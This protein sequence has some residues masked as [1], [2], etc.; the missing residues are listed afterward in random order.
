MKWNQWKIALLLVLV[1]AGSVALVGRKAVSRDSETPTSAPSTEP[2]TGAAVGN[3]APD[4]QLARSDGT[5]VTNTDLKGHPALLVFWTAWCPVC[6]E[7]A[8][9]I[10]A[11]AARYEPR[12]VQVLGI[13]IMDS[14]ARTG[15]GI[16][17]FGIR[18]PVVRDTDASVARRYR[19]M[20]TPTIVFLDR[21]GVIR[22]VGNGLPPDYAKRLD[23][24]IAEI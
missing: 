16:K 7:E 18:Y 13:N 8:P 11:L 9:H 4:F 3:R 15:S 19:V 1:L 21:M 22:Y 14:E 12:G 5:T 20:G 6:K 17:D 24:L 2:T 23:A 10:N